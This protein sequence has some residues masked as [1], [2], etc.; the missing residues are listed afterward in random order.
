MSRGPRYVFLDVLRGLAVLWMIQVHVTNVFLDPDLRTGWF[1]ELLNISNGFVAPAFLFCAGSGLWIALSRKGAD[2]L[3][4]GAA[5]GGYL[6]RMSYILF[7][8]YLLHVPTFSLMGMLDLPSDQLLMGLQVDVLQTIVFASLLVLAVFLV[9]RNLQRTS[10]V[11]AV[12]AAAISASTVV[13]WQALTSSA[14]I[15]PLTIMLTPRSPFPLFP[16]M[17]YLFAG[18]FF[19]QVFMQADNKKRLAQWMVAL[20]V[21]VP[22]VLFWV[23]GLAF[24]SPWTSV[25]WQASPPGQLIRLCGIAMAFG[26]LFLLEERLQ[27]SSAGRSLQLMGMESLFLYLSHLMLVYGNGP[28]ITEA[29]FGFEL[30]GF[31]GVVVIWLVVT[32]P[33]VFIARWW[34]QLK[35]ERPLVARWMLVIQVS[36]IVLS[37]LLTPPGFQWVDVLG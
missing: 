6:Q 9:L 14:A 25:G 20:G 29:I 16:W 7:W 24:T 34:H 13:V 26:G 21:L 22:V 8:A 37:F 15:E 19:T 33:L 10:V 3:K 28:I 1:F 36:W 5:L 32:V 2:Y 4:H 18:V 12:L 23:K 35:K 27:K 17:A 30:T 11:V 31:L